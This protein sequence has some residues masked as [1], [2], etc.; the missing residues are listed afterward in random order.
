MFAAD[1]KA[2]LDG[3][4]AAGVPLELLALHTLWARF[5]SGNVSFA[6][7]VAPASAA[8]RHGFDAHPYYVSAVSGKGALARLRA[9]P[10]LARAFLVGGRPPRVG[11]RCCARPALAD[12][13]DAV[14]VKG[15]AALYVDRAEALAAD[16]R[17]A[18][19]R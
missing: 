7:L 5:G 18:G 16:A 13:L 1:P 2:S 17:A 9:S 6:S 12:T 14:A 19:G 15:P 4:L 3:G 8:A 10:A 11:E